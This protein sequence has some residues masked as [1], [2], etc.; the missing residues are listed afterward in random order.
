ML[1]TK[2][3]SSVP[4]GPHTMPSKVVGNNKPSPAK[5]ESPTEVQQP[6]KEATATAPPLPTEDDERQEA[7]NYVFKSKIQESMKTLE[8]LNAEHRKKAAEAK[9]KEVAD[10]KNQEEQERK[11]VAEEQLA[12]QQKAQQIFAANQK[13]V[14]EKQKADADAAAKQLEKQS[15]T[16]VVKEEEHIFVQYGTEKDRIPV[17]LTHT[18]DEQLRNMLRNRY[19]GLKA[20]QVVNLTFNLN[21]KSIVLNQNRPLSFYQVFSG[22]TISVDSRTSGGKPEA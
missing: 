12:A 7:Q 19:P 3:E 20:A 17:S 18:T 13:A 4:P 22:S 9:D 6:R 16:A 11:R 21:Q 8:D 5:Q 14:L 1:P 15:T 2:D 10:K